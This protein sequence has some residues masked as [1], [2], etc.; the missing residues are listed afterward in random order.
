MPIC[1]EG[2]AVCVGQGVTNGLDYTYVIQS[3]RKHPLIV[4]LF[5]LSFRGAFLCHRELQCELE[6]QAERSIGQMS[7]ML[8]PCTDGIPGLL[9][10]SRTE[11]L[12]YHV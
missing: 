8:R 5:G 2:I 3:A 6:D 10:K 1:R 9:P 4:Q 12:T 11:D 7:S